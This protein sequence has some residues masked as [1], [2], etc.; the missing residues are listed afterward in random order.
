M[1][2]SRGVKLNEP[3]RPN[4]APLKPI[5]EGWRRYALLG[6]IAIAV[7]GVLAAL[8]AIQLIAWWIATSR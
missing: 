7:V 6:S 2:S 1:R 3:H 5:A 4:R 8:G